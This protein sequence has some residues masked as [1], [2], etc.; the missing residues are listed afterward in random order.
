M[1]S[2]DSNLSILTSLVYNPLSIIPWYLAGTD[3]I[4][5]KIIA[6]L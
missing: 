1:R 6:L 2:T 3:L 4:V 5:E